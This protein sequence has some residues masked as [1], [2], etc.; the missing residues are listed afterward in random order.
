MLVY[1]KEKKNS[2]NG[3]SNKKSLITIFGFTDTSLT[4]DLS[5]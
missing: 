2:I 5:L 4:R 1:K 3:Q